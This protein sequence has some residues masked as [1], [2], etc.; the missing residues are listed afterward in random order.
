MQYLPVSTKSAYHTLDSWI[1]KNES[2]CIPAY[3][4]VFC[5]GILENAFF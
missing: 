5:G 4:I 3:K 2:R 1:L